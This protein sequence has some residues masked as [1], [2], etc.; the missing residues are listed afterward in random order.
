[1]KTKANKECKVTTNAFGKY[2]YS[3]ITYLS[4]L[5]NLLGQYN[6]SRN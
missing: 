3:F 1:M 2:V 4:T 5:V 6:L